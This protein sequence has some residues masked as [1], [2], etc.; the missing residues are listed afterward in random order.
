MLVLERQNDKVYYNGVELKIN[1]QASK[2]PGNEVVFVKNCPE[3]NGQTWVS[4]SRLKEGTNELECKAREFSATNKYTLTTE[5]AARI[6]EIQA[7]IDAIK[8]AAKARY[9]AKPNLNADPSKMTEAERLA[10]IEQIKAYY[11]F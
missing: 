8:D 1:K 6:A 2:G 9:V 4:L 7:E 10:A 3:A 11:G 5:E